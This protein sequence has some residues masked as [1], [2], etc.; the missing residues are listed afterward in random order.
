MGDGGTKAQPIELVLTRAQADFYVRQA[1]PVSDLSKRHGQELVPTRE[2]TNPIVALVTID[3]AAKLFAMNPVH[4]LTENWC[5]GTH[6]ASL[7]LVVLRKNA[8]RSQNRS[9]RFCC[10]NRSYSSRFNKRRLSQPDDSDGKHGVAGAKKMSKNTALITLCGRMAKYGQTVI[11]QKT[12][13]AK[14]SLL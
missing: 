8:N 14:W 5:C 9:H 7:A 1:I 2:A 6:P 10:A 12:N 13:H 11:R 4:D 3:A